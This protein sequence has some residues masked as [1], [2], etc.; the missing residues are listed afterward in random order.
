[1]KYKSRIPKMRRL[2]GRII[3]ARWGHWFPLS[4]MKWM[5]CEPDWPTIEGEESTGRVLTPYRNYVD[6]KFTSGVRVVGPTVLLR[7]E[8]RS[9]EKEWIWRPHN[10][11]S[12]ND[13]Q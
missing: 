1:M 13:S 2:I 8:I 6:C 10:K 5:H 12:T 9:K 3:P 11:E 4:W 7:C